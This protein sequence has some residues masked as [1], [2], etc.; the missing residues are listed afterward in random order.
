[1][2]RV[3]Y[4]GPAQAMT[5]IAM[6]EVN[7][8]IQ[9]LLT[10]MP[11]VQGGKVRLLATT[12]TRR[13]SELPDVPTVSAMTFFQRLTSCCRKR[14]NSSAEPVAISTPCVRSRSM[15]SGSAVT[16]VISALS[17]LTMAR[18]VPAGASTPYHR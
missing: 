10:A 16:R 18:G 2:L 9:G 11:F 7:M 13:W 5:A 12:G 8:A 1:M 6:S 15:T 4:K 14:A 3:P 17:L